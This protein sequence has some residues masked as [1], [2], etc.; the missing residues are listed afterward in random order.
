MLQVGERG[1]Q[2]KKTV[3][4][5]WCKKMKRKKKKDIFTG[6]IKGTCH[7]FFIGFFIRL[8]LVQETKL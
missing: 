6:E 4:H 8:L 7:N 2:D 5:W 1:R 3:E